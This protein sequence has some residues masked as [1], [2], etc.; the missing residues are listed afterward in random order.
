LDKP[1]MGHMGDPEA[2]GKIIL[3]FILQMW[4]CKAWA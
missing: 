1:E 4:G 3:K 2:D